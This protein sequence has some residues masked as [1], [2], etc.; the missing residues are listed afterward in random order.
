MS[1]DRLTITL[2]E[3]L[4]SAVD[5]TIDGSAVRNRS[6]A[7]E[8]LIRRGLYLH[9]LTTLVITTLE[10]TSAPLIPQLVERLKG[11]NI[12]HCM[13]I[14]DPA[15][16]TWAL[17]VAA[18]LENLY[19]ELTCRTVP[20]DFGTA[21]AL[22]LLTSELTTPFVLVQVAP[23]TVLP[24]SFLSLYTAHR[25]SDN[26][27]THLITTD[28]GVTF[29]TSSCS[30]LDPSFIAHVPAGHATLQTVFSLL[31]KAGKVGTYVE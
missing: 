5:G 31:A 23:D 17:E 7:I 20:G 22:T 18:S 30:V 24:Q 10:P 16:P 3:A 6:H 19:P 11:T 27:V 25:H 21:A 29:R 12:I 2:D 15:Q 28:D 4:L 1:R 9:E 8:H 13:I 14:T 26:V